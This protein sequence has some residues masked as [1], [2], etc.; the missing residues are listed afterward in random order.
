MNCFTHVL[1]FNPYD[2]RVI[3]FFMCEKI[4][5]QRGSQGHRWQADGS[6]LDN[7]EISLDLVSLLH[8]F[9]IFFLWERHLC[10]G[11]WMYTV[12][13]LVPVGTVFPPS[14]FSVHIRTYTLFPV[15]QPYVLKLTL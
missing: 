3:L 15:L 11:L 12:L 1:S 5:V 14:V 13:E 7:G 6:L 10:A 9:V 8:P 4:E 2:Q